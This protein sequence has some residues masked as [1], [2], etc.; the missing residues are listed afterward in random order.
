VIDWPYHM[1]LFT[2]GCAAGIINALAGGGPIL[3]LG[4]LS[5][6]GIDP[7]IA[8]LTSTVALSP[9]QLVAGF[10]ARR[11]LR[12]SRLGRPMILTVCAVISGGVGAALL[13]VTTAPAFRLLVGSVSV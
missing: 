6:T 10:M 12:E 9:G 8:N 5:L 11:S 4:M 2:T 7:R 3:T 13:L 1:L